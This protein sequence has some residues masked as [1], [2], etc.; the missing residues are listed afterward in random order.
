MVDKHNDPGFDEAETAPATSEWDTQERRSFPRTGLAVPVHLTVVPGGNSDSSFSGNLSGVTRDVSRGGC[1]IITDQ[2]VADRTRCIARF[3]LA[4][5]RIEPDTVWAEVRRSR[6]QDGSVLLGLEFDTPLDALRIAPGPEREA[7]P[8][9]R[10]VLIV[11]DQSGIRGLLTRYLGERG[12]LVEAAS[13]GEEAFRM[14]KQ[15]PPDVM[16]L[17]LY[18]P[19]LNGHDLLRRMREMDISV[20][21]IFTMSGYADTSDAQECLR[22][23]AIDHLLKPIDP[24]HLY[25]SILLRLGAQPVSV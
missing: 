25:R 24:E 9:S 6:L 20:D 5:G 14:V 1:A 18:L 15:S 10:K 2:E 8:D 22:L 17:D 4:T 23:G 7:L 21:L 3:P 11:D 13:D 16:L 19:R 12:F